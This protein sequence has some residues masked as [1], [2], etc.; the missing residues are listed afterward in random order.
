MS[1]RSISANFCRH[2]A[3]VGLLAVSMCLD[4]CS[5][6][7]K[8][9]DAINVTATDVLALVNPYVG[10]QSG[11]ADFGTGGGAGNTFPGA[12]IPFGMVQLSPDTSPSTD[13]FAGGYTYSDSLIKGF[14]L[15]HISGAGCAIYQDVPFLPVASEVTE[16][17]VSVGSAGFS[18][19]YLAAFTHDHEAA[20]PGYYQVRLNPQGAAPIDVDLTATTRGGMMRMK[21]STGSPANLLINPGGSAM[22]NALAQVH[23]DPQLREVSG[24]SS[25]GRFCYQDNR[26]TVYFVAQFDHPFKSWAVWRKLVFTRNGTDASDSSPLPLNYGPVPGGPSSIPGN[27]SGTA[28]AGAVLSFDTQDDQPVVMR[29]AI[30]YV[31]TVNARQNL[32]RE[33]AGLAFD[34]VRS[35]AQSTWRK[36]L[37][38]VQ[39]E[40][41]GPAWRR[42]FYTALYH[43]LLSPNVFSDANGDYLGMDN[44]VHSTSRTAQYQNFSGWDIY[45]SQVPLLALL[46]PAR[47]SD[48]VQSLVEDANQNGWLPKWSYAN[49]QT[50]TMVGDPADLIIAGAYAF[51][52]RGFDTSSALNAMMKGATSSGISGNPASLTNG[53]VERQAL[54]TY[55][56]LGYVPHDLDTPLGGIG[57]VASSEYVWGSAATTLEYALA[58]FGIA[59]FADAIGQSGQVASIRARSANWRNLVNPGTE[60]IEPRLAVGAFV[61][62]YDASGGDGFVEGNG[63]QY[64]WFVPHDIAGL[65]EATGGQDQA[66]ARLDGFFSQINA[67]PKA[68]YAYLGNEPTL[69]TP[70]I[71]AWLHQPSKTSAIVRQALTTL[72]DDTAK[73]MP[74]N[75]DL[76]TMSAWWVLSS[77]GLNPGIPGTNVLLINAPLFDSATLDLPS[78]R[79]RITREAA[80]G[81]GSIQSAMLGAEPLDRAWLHASE[82]T[83]K[84]NLSFVLGTA[85]SSWA[86]AMGSEPP[87]NSR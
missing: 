72:Y 1:R 62:R 76:G 70:W 42:I 85:E 53:Y 77:L 39:V 18:S 49:Q 46:D 13:N 12:T 73:G 63:A 40:G 38:R 36:E 44:Q 56:S 50:D 45:R 29:V 25:S 34:E 83:S 86:T 52:A 10:T 65:I 51:G 78:G 61:P 20:S 81:N 5:R 67:G 2:A 3:T 17:P 74:G 59:Q 79:V 84:G 32:E 15:T 64:S 7:G 58:D 11:A 4:G 22:A 26:Y 71:Y 30:S 69:F 54:S 24:Q 28:Q 47:T 14:S 8:P 48:M 82:L 75:D 60:A 19:Q 35:G 23:I 16:A 57:Y 6:S 43:S 80:D 41:G 31:S 9:V 37:S 33:L 66:S 27:P 87:S 55:D 68:P 21:Y